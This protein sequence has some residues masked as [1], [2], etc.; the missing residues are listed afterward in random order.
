[1]YTQGDT[2]KDDDDDDDDAPMLVEM[3]S[4]SD[5][6]RVS[7]KPRYNLKLPTFAG[8]RFHVFKVLFESTAEDMGWSEKQKVSHLVHA[9]RDE[10]QE[11]IASMGRKNWTAKGIMEELERVYIKNKSYATVQ[12]ELYDMR[13]KPEQTIYHFAAQIQSAARPAD[14]TDEKREWLIEVHLCLVCLNILS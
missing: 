6:S 9:L 5:E 14:I 10:P 8:K 2:T 4:T 3:T 12:T 11:L 1:M 7:G 13:R